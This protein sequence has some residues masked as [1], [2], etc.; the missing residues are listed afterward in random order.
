[1]ERTN[2]F[3]LLYTLPIKGDIPSQL[4]YIPEE[5]STA[6]WGAVVSFGYGRREREKKAGAAAVRK[7]KCAS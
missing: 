7:P 4:S 1:M 5:T 3:H 6:E 2:R